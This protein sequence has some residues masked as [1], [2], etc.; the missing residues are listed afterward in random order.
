LASLLLLTKKPKSMKKLILAF[1]V[2]P[3]FMAAQAE[4]STVSDSAWL[5][6]YETALEKAAKEDKNIFLILL[7]FN[8]FQ[9]TMFC[10]TSIFL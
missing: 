6:N 7:S 8:K 1:I 4:K 3:F 5:T 9:M 2:F 10:F